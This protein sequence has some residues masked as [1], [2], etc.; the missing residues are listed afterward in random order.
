V[1]TTHN[2]K[3]WVLVACIVLTFL[4]GIGIIILVIYLLVRLLQPATACSYCE[5]ETVAAPPPVSYAPM[6][7]PY[8]PAPPYGYYA[9]PAPTGWSMASGSR[10]CP[11]CYQPVPP[12]NRY[13]PGCGRNV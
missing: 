12:G 4:F 7:M 13:C 1:S 9:H 3:T 6:A 10:P 2:I 8:A 5:G 11:H